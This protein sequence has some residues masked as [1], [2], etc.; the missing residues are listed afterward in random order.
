ME[1]KL[2]TS[3]IEARLDDME[4]RIVAFGQGEMRQELMAWQVE[5]MHRR[6]PNSEQ[7]DDHTTDTL[8]WPR[9]RTYA[10][11]HRWPQNARPLTRRQ[12]RPTAATPRL[13]GVAP[14]HRPILREE[15]FDRLIERFRALLPEKLKW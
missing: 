1:F 14:A 10:E 8:I 2:D 7:P 9:S 6:F 5:D 11:T 12:M 3:A 4:N 15:L 13:R